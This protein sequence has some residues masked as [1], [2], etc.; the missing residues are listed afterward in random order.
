MYGDQQLTLVPT[1]R[2]IPL[3]RLVIGEMARF[4]TS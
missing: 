4:L 2:L 3:R 1:A